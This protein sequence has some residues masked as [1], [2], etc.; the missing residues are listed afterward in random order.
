MRSTNPD[1]ERWN[2]ISPEPNTNSSFRW[3]D[4]AIISFLIFLVIGVFAA[5]VASGLEL[6][7]SAAD[8]VSVKID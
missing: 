6:N 1:P 7:M 8:K 3:W 4:I 2:L 5:A